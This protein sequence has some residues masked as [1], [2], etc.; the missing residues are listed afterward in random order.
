MLLTRKPVCPSVRQF[1][2][3]FCL[4][5]AFEAVY[6]YLGLS[7]FLSEADI[8]VTLFSGAT[9]DS[10]LID[11]AL[12]D[13]TFVQPLVMV[14]YEFFVTFFSGTTKTALMFRAAPSRGPLQC[15]WISRLFCLP[16]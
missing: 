3:L 8:F 13:F 11:F 4:F 1:V 12:T 14:K 10:H 9:D 16:S 6:T 15:L 2:I 5:L 7:I